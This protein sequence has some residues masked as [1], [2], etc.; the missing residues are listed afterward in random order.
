[1]PETFALNTGAPGACTCEDPITTV[2]YYRD[3]TLQSEVCWE[4]VSA[5]LL[6]L[7]LI[8]ELDVCRPCSWEEKM[9]IKWGVRG[10]TRTYVESLMVSCKRKWILPHRDKH[11]WPRSKRSLRSVQGEGSAAVGLAAAPHQC[12]RATKAPD[13]PGLTF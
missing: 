13:D 10:Q 4:I 8:Q 2:I 7:H 12:V 3:L 11:T 6:P 5:R 1:M 9:A